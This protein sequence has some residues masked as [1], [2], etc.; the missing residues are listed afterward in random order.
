MVTN[1]HGDIVLNRDEYK[2]LQDKLEEF[3][4]ILMYSSTDTK[5]YNCYIRNPYKEAVIL[6]GSEIC[7][8]QAKEYLEYYKRGY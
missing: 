8:E 5:T 3:G 7:K 6:Y 1:Q 2:L 4:I